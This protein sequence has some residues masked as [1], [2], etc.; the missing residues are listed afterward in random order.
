MNIVQARKTLIVD[1]EIE[2]L[3]TLKLGLRSRGYEAVTASNAEYALQQLNE[4]TNRF[5]IVLTDYSMPGMNGLEFLK[6]IRSN[7]KDMSVVMMTAHGRKELLVDALRNQCDGFIEKP[8]TMDELIEEIERVILSRIRDTNTHELADFIPQLLHQINNPLSAIVGSAQL[9]MFQTDNVNDTKE[10]L[11]CILEATQSIM[12]INKEIMNLGKG[13]DSTYETVDLTEVVNQCLS[14]FEDL[15]QFKGVKIEKDFGAGSHRIEGNRF[16]LDQV[17]RNLVLN[18]ID[19]MDGAY[20]KKLLISIHNNPNLT[21]NVCI[22]DTGCG[23]PQ[24]LSDQIFSSYFTTKQGGTG[25]GLS[26]VKRIV[27]K[28][29]GRIDVR[30][31]VGE[32]TSFEVILPLHEN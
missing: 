25:L 1:D 21:V 28:H 30:S 19:S 31:Q 17:F 7:Q 23:M 15:L 5:D 27:D 24:E 14:S 29:K 2:Q 16:G 11:S 4:K 22:E 18:A 32:G 10:R 8:F 26:V 12:Q 3:R 6:K 9:A 20:E 13:L